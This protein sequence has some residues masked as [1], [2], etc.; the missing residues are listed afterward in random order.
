MKSQRYIRFVPDQSTAED[1]A[2]NMT[3]QHA[4][5]DRAIFAAMPGPADNW[6]IVDLLTAIESEMPYS[7]QA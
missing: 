2:R 4:K 1:A 6:A 7:W 5:G 3:R